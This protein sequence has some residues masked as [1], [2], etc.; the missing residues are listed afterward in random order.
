VLCYCLSFYWFSPRVPLKDSTPPAP[1]KVQVLTVGKTVTVN[2]TTLPLPAT[3]ADVITL[4]GKPS[5]IVEVAN[6]ILTWDEHGLY[7]TEDPKPEQIIAFTVALDKRDYP[8]WPKKLFRG[9]ARVDG[10]IVTARSTIKDIN[11]SKKGESFTRNSFLPDTWSIAHGDVLLTLVEADPKL[12]NDKAN[13]SYLQ[14]GVS[15]KP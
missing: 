6:T 12:K 7:A 10:A 5:R 9:T 11:H 14:I 3:R 13:F 15:L 1:E 8:Y 2:G 4:L